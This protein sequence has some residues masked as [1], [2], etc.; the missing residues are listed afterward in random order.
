MSKLLG[1]D[2]FQTL[3][4]EECISESDTFTTTGTCLEY[5][6]EGRRLSR[7]RRSH[8]FT[9]RWHRHPPLSPNLIVFYLCDSSLS[10]W[11]ISIL[12]VTNILSAPTSSLWV[13]HTFPALLSHGLTQIPF[14]KGPECL[15][16]LTQT[17]AYSHKG[18][19]ENV[20]LMFRVQCTPE[21]SQWLTSIIV[22]YRDTSYKTE[23]AQE[24]HRSCR[25]KEER[26]S[27]HPWLFDK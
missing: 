18:P 24:E 17:F 10:A 26:G 14:T 15:E 16:Q 20:R 13:Y 19:L 5:L 6:G 3:P 8:V 12:L 22:E 25:R 23:T 4:Y 21:S 2:I 1:L 9:A 27:S 11:D 7:T